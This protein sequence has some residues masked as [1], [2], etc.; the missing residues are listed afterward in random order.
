MADKVIHQIES[1]IDSTKKKRNE[2]KL[3]AYELG[4]ELLFNTKKSLEYLESTLGINDARY[5]LVSD[6]LAQEAL[7]CGIDYFKAMKDN[8][9]FSESNAL[10]ILNTAKIISNNVQTISRIED[11][12][13]G[14]HDWVKAQIQHDSHNKIYDFNIILLKTA[15]SFMTCDGDIDPNEVALIKKMAKEEAVFGQIDI[16]EELDNFIRGIN[17]MGIS[18]LKNY[19]SIVK[20]TEFTPDQELSLVDMAVNTLYADGRVDYNEIRFFRIFRSLLG[21]S[22]ALIKKKCPQLTDEFFES[23]IFS[24]SFLKQLFDDYFDKIEMPLFDNLH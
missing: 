13:E 20:N 6:N 16:D 18:Y 24:H 15:F 14:I 21:V 9:R 8:S 4:M 2:N 17:S 1:D 7:Q 5:M 10:E 3:D 11:N 19:I 23:D 22:D 12:I